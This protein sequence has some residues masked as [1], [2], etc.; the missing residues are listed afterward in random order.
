MSAQNKILGNNVI[1]LAQYTVGSTLTP[2]PIAYARNCE[3]DSDTDFVEKSGTQ[4]GKW[5]EFEPKR[6]GWKMSVTCLLADD[7]TDVWQAYNNHTL[8]DVYFEDAIGA[9]WMWSGKAYIKHIK[10]TG[11][12]DQMASFQVEFQGT[13]ALTYSVL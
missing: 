12:I 2:V 4:Q 10:A 9:D 5:K 11:P 6:S 8:L 7:E 3:V 1:L 13:G